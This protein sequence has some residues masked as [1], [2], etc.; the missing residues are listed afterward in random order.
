MPGCG[1][2]PLVPPSE[3]AEMHPGAVTPEPSIR[4]ARVHGCHVLFAHLRTVWVVATLQLPD[5]PRNEPDALGL[6]N[7]DRFVDC[8]SFGIRKNHPPPPVHIP[9]D[10]R[11][12]AWGCCCR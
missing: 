4:C 5:A 9:G 6:Q 1:F 11:P 3:P 12:L 2:P 7:L 8:L 10:G